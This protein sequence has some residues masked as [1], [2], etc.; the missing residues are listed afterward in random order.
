MSSSLEDKLFIEL[1][2][3]N[4][5]QTDIFKKLETAENYK[6]PQI[7]NP[8]SKKIDYIK[9]LISED[10]ER[11]KNLEKLQIKKEVEDIK[12]QVDKIHKKI[13]LVEN[14][15]QEIKEVALELKK[16]ILG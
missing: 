6:T 4:N 13:N 5:K 15:L 3:I 10:L 7:T 16:L 14:S 9:D 2:K 1:S 12:T 8:I 11:H